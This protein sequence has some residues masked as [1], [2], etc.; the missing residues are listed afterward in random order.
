MPLPTGSEIF[1]GYLSQL[2]FEN[3]D[4]PS[5]TAADE[6][7][8]KHFENYLQDTLVAEYPAPILERLTIEA[9]SKYDMASVR[10]LL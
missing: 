2:E 10:K 9:S 8:D 1:E 6:D 4:N 5:A 7:L 3:D